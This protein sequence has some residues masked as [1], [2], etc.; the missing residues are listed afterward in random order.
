[1]SRSTLR[2][3]L[4]YGQPP[5]LAATIE[6]AADN[7]HPLARVEAPFALRPGEPL[8]LRIFLDGPVLE[9]FAY[10]RQAITQQVFPSLAESDRVRIC[11]QGG[12]AM[13]VEGHCWQ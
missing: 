10:D 2:T 5:F 8:R 4:T 7:P 1:M 6:Q 9:V 12:A 3:D 13:V 11:T